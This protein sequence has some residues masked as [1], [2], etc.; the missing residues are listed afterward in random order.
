MTAPLFF[1]PGWGVGTGPL[2]ST[3]EALG[4]TLRH[5][6]GYGGTPLIPA[7]DT[8]ADELAAAVPSGATLMGWSLGGSLALNAAAR[9]PGHIGRVITIGSTACFVQRD[10]WPHAELPESLAAFTEAVEADPAAMLPRF[11][12]NFN[13]GDRQAKALT[14]RILEDTGPLAPPET[15]AT[16]LR[17]LAELDIRAQLPRITCPVLLL[18]GDHDPLVPLAAAQAMADAIPGA[19]LRALPDCAHAPFLSDPAC[20]AGHVTTFLA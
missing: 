15:L 1:L 5:L 8:A 2:Q 4:A 13:R 20:F 17:W 7:F 10:G 11:V 6:P 9:H 18:L 14:R 12:G 19:T 16:G 3:A